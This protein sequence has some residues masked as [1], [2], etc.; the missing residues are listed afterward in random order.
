MRAAP[1]FKTASKL[2]VTGGAA[3]YLAHSFDLQQIISMIG[4]ASG[5]PVFVAA[6]LT[7]AQLLLLAWRWRLIH[8]SVTGMGLPL[9]LFVIGLGRGLLFG[10]F[11]PPIVG[12]DAIRIGSIA[13][14][15]GLETALRSVVI[16]RILGMTSLAAIATATLPYF[17]YAVDDGFETKTLI[18]A[19]AATLL[20]CAVLLAWPSLF[21]RAPAVGPY[22]TRTVG[23]LRVMLAG[24]SGKLLIVL[25]LGAQAL[26]ALI[27]ASLTLAVAPGAPILL[28]AIVVFPAMLIASLPVTLSGWG[29]REVVVASAFA[30]AGADPAA[31]AA[32]SIFLGLTNLLP[33]VYAEI[34]GLLFRPQGSLPKRALSDAAPRS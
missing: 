26:S 19:S 1:A 34:F 32:A 30:L 6:V 11:L 16:D 13:K 23:D 15:S 12:A 24:R 17:A 7:F 29:V 10:Q 14:T 22:L 8:A 20:S 27:M 9:P 5:L 18:A 28:S 25:A 4:R 33:G 3:L 2:A 31:G 21:V